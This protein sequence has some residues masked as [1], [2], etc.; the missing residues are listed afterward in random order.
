MLCAFPQGVEKRNPKGSRIFCKES[1]T[2]FSM[3]CEHSHRSRAYQNGIVR[4][5]T[6][7]IVAICK[8]ESGTNGEKPIRAKGPNGRSNFCWGFSFGSRARQSKF[9]PKPRSG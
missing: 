6:D 1:T 5:R 4:L 7:S 9:L 3:Q 2:H 8:N